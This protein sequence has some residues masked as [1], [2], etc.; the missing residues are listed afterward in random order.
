MIVQFALKCLQL[1]SQRDIYNKARKKTHEQKLITWRRK[2]KK[3]P[4]E[5]LKIFQSPKYLSKAKIIP[6]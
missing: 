1:L 5:I 3:F 6:K 4:N 2:T